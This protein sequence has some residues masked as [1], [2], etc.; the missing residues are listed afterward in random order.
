MRYFTRLNNLRLLGKIVGKIIIC[1]H[2]YFFVHVLI[3]TQPIRG[4]FSVLFVIVRLF[5]SVVRKT[6]K[7]FKIL[8]E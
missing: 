3:V 1:L 8:H 5:I 6:V 4:L 7:K 2:V